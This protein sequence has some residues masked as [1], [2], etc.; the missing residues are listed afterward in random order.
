[1]FRKRQEVGGRLGVSMSQGALGKRADKRDCVLEFQK[2]DTELLSENEVV[3]R[4]QLEDGFHDL[5]GQQG[6]T[7][8]GTAIPGW[9]RL[10]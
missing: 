5:V 6:S 10:R 7:L 1:M 2:E 4:Q 3:K 8:S 9:P